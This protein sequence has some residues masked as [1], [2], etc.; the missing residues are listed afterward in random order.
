MKVGNM[1]KNFAKYGLV[2]FVCLFLSIGCATM[3]SSPHMGF[4]GIEWQ[5]TMNR[6]DYVILNNVEGHSETLSILFGLVQIIDGSK[7]RL[8]WFI[9]FYEEKTA[10]IPGSMLGYF[11][12]TESRAYYDALTKSPEA[13]VI[14][15]KSINKSFQGVPLLLNIRCVTYSGKAIKIKPE[16]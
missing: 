14:L 5:T 13:D 8:F 11:P 12:S 4:K 3:T 6:E 1:H 7:V 2:V 9:P 15:C 16:K 10:R